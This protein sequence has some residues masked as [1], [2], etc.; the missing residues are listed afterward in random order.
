MRQPDADAHYDPDPERLRR[1]IQ[2]AG[3][4]LPQVARATG[5]GLRT[6]ERYLSPRAP[7]KGNWIPYPL[8][9]TIEALCT[10]RRHG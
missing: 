7:A 3:L 8:Q 1:L 6:I 9:F 4:T 5:V 2:E 10:S